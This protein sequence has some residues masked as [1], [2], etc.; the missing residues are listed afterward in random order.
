MKKIIDILIRYY[1]IFLLI[2]TWQ[3]LSTFNV[4]PKFLLPSPIDVVNAFI[5]DFSLIMKHTKYT[6]IEAFSGLF[7]GTLFAF[8]LSIIMDRFDFM[9]KTTMPM[10][11]ITQTIPTVA[12]APLLVLWFGYG[13]SSK[14]LLVI[15][16]T[17]FPITVALLDGYRSVDKE[18]LIL[19]KSMGANK[20]QEY[21]HVKLPSSLNY[22]LQDLEYLYH[23]H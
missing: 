17:F 14:I 18:S 12:I 16:T 6:I 15:I 13:M 19:L 20:L 21:V 9:Y 7:L 23:I 4:V 22:F 2:I 5:K 11:I 1:L 10:L 3:L 8:I